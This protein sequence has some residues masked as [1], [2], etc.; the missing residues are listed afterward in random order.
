MNK[1]EKFNLNTSRLLPS[2][3]CELNDSKPSQ[4]KFPF[5][6]FIQAMIFDL[7]FRSRWESKIFVWTRRSWSGNRR[8]KW[9]F[10]GRTTGRWKRLITCMWVFNLYEIT[11]ACDFLLMHEQRKDLWWLETLTTSLKLWNLPSK[12]FHFSDSLRHW[13]CH[14]NVSFFAGFRVKNSEGDER[15]RLG[16]LRGPKQNSVDVNRI[17][18]LFN[19][20]HNDNRWVFLDT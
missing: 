20:R 2:T 6:L 9:K 1:I 7:F 10:S 3:T 17:S 12:K 14:A 18:F 4:R 16:W 19:H 13:N 15:R 8:R 11:R 5:E